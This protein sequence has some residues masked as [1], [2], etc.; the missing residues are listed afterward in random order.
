MGLRVL[1]T[2]LAATYSGPEVARLQ[3]LFLGPLELL[4]VLD[5][6]HPKAEL[7]RV[8]MAVSFSAVALDERR[9]SEVL[10]TGSRAGQGLSTALG[11]GTR[12]LQ[13]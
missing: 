4:P 12:V 8:V 6:G 3:G 13:R 11:A 2:H 5:G 10:Q 7:V 1:Y 9:R